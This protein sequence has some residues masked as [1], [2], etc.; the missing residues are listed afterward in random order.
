MILRTLLPVRCAG[1][2]VAG[3]SPCE[4]CAR[5]LAP[6]PV[7]PV[8][9][10]LDACWSLVAYEGVG[11][12]L[13]THLKYRRDRAALGWLAAGMAH[14][15]SPPRGVVVTW[16]PTTDARRRQRGYDQAELLARAVARQWSVSCRPLLRRCAGPPQTGRSLADR[17]EGPLLLARAGSRAVVAGAPVV[18]VDDVLT[19]GSTLGAAARALRAVDVGSTAGL[20]AA[21]TPSHQAAPPCVLAPPQ[22]VGKIA[23]VP[24]TTGR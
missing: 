24:A 10:G 4:R 13:V 11:R 8:P 12:L 5:G 6:A 9:P 1:C 7:G 14:L 19:T 21:R 18:I 23:Q 17:R 16:A 22:M 15:L 2:G 20:T 3:M